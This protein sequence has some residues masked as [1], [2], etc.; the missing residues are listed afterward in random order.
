MQSNHNPNIVRICQDS[1]SGPQ[2]NIA[3]GAT[4]SADAEGAACRIC[5]LWWVKQGF[6]RESTV[7]TVFGGLVPCLKPFEP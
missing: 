6:P 3:S 5:E 1:F 2:G 4:C 7:T